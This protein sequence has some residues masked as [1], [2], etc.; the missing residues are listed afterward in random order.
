MFNTEIMVYCVKHCPVI[1]LPTVTVVHTPDFLKSC[2]V[3]HSVLALLQF[4]QSEAHMAHPNVGGVR[5]YTTSGNVIQCGE[6]PRHC[7]HLLY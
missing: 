2:Q 5:S 4:S 3:L 6:I 1:F 7:S